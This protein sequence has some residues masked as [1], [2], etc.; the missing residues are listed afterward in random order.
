MK[1]FS[2]IIIFIF[3]FAFCTQS[4]VLTYKD[5]ISKTYDLQELAQLPENGESGALFSSYDRASRYDEKSSSYLRWRAN[6]DGRGCFRKEGNN[7]TVMADIKGAG[8]I[9]RMWSASTGE[10][11]VKIYLDGKL[12][13]DLPWKDYFNRKVAPFNRKGLV[14]Y[15][16][17]TSILP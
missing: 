4:K 14:Y 3:C 8:V 15:M 1:S 7:V 16:P 9:W 13:V 10:G 2:L 5:V 11:K 6:D 17:L 12:V